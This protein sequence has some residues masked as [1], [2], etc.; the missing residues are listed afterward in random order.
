MASIER[1]EYN[2]NYYQKNK[3]KLDSNAKKWRQNN[4]EK[5][6]EFQKQY[7]LTEVYKKHRRRSV[8][9]RYGLSLEQYEEML[10]LQ[11]GV[12]YI[13]HQPET[14]KAWGKVKQLCVDHNHITNKVRKLLCDSCNLLLASVKE[15]PTILKNAINYLENH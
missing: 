10:K 4:P 2:R 1:Q 5:L 6:K 13:C 14:R 8:Y 7:R 11:N 15:N 9:Y 3:D 12:C